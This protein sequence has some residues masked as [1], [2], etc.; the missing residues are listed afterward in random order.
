MTPPTTEHSKPYSNSTN[1][2]RLDTG[3]LIA[4]HIDTRLSA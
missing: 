3:L 2:R 1:N 4:G